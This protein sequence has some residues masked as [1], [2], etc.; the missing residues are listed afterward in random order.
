MLRSSLPLL[1]WALAPGAVLGQY[2]DAFQSPLGQSDL[3]YFA[4][5]PL[6]AYELLLAHLEEHPDDYDALWRAARAAVVVGVAK[7][8]EANV[9]QNRYFDPAI[10]LA[11]QAVIQRPDGIDG[12][13]WRGV[14]AGLRALNASSGYA[15]EL[16]QMA[17][18]DAHAIL[19]V[20]SLHAGAHNILGKLHYE[21]MSLSRIERVIARV[22]V[23]N[24]ALKDTSWEHAE[25]HLT[26][27]VELAPDFV[28]YQFDLGVL[29]EKRGRDG[30]AAVR[31]GAALALPPVQPID[32]GLQA[33]AT[34]LL[35][36]LQG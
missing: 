2:V 34:V 33:R 35:E 22:F 17:F 20:D 10:D 4:D 12:L 29:Y 13:Y 14:A 21:I 18:E 7:E 9:E 3:L 8:D 26:R 28:L 11:G 6:A 36:G 5:E 23:T 19:A 27:A 32:P 30:E 24:D 31:L 25:Q 15:S 16:A 1:L